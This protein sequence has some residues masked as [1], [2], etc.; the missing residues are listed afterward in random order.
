MKKKDE[1]K[2]MEKEHQMIKSADG[3]AGLLHQIANVVERSV[4]LDEGRGRR[5]QSN[6]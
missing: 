3:S 4:D 6:G 5:R 1:T 2:K